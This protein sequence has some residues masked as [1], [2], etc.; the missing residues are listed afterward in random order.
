MT[1]APGG[2]PLV[3]DA[4]THRYPGG[5]IAVENINLDVKGGEII[6]LL[7]TLGRGRTTLLGI[8]AGFNGKTEGRIIIGGKIHKALPTSRSAVEILFQNYALFPHLT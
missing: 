1:E 3:L 4:I 6:A 7:A 5:A 2:R 8:G